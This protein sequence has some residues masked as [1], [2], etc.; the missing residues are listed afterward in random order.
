MLQLIYDENARVRITSP[1]N[2]LL[3]ILN[4]RIFQKFFGIQSM[5]KM[6][7]TV[8]FLEP[9]VLLQMMTALLWAANANPID[10]DILSHRPWNTIFNVPPNCPMI[11]SW[12]HQS[13]FNKPDLIIHWSSI[14]TQ[15][16]S[17]I[18]CL[19]HPGNSEAL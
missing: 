12:P 2:W 16:Q 10:I 1:T 11:L 9:L 4:R 13:Q 14:K 17:I 18:N 8:L 5:E 7:L 6:F 15:D 3:Q 19:W